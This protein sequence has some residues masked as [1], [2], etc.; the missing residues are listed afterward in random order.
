MALPRCRP[1]FRRIL[2]EVSQRCL[3]GYSTLTANRFHEHAAAM[4]VSADDLYTALLADAEL[5]PPNWNLQG[6]QAEI[7]KQL[8]E[9]Y[10]R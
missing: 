2:C 4:G 1:N 10:L 8:S 3:L 5:Q 7:W 9:Y 6:R